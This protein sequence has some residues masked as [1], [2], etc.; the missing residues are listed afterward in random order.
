MFY[1]P[2]EEWI[3]W[4]GDEDVLAAWDGSVWVR[5]AA[6]SPDGSAWKD[7]I[8]ID[9]SSG[10]VSMPFTSL[11][12]GP[13]VLINGNFGINRRALTI[14]ALADGPYGVDR[15][16]GV[17]ATDIGWDA[18]TQTITLNSGAIRRVVEPLLWGYSNLATF[19]VTVS[20]EGL[21]GGNLTVTV[22]SVS[23]VITPG[24]GRRSVTLTLGAGD[25]GNLNVTLTPA[26]YPTW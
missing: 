14:D 13:S 12:V 23:G 18:A 16:K 15:C 6:A 3:A 7:A 8:Q 11:G 4:I 21:T 24:S 26:S 17:G 10:E 19:Q 20:V 2:R 9:R 22:G 5:P 1:T 25:T